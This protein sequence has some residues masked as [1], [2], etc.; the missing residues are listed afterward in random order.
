MAKLGILLLL[1]ICVGLCHTETYSSVALLKDQLAKI[2][3]DKVR[4]ELKDLIV[5]Q[6][7]R[8]DTIK[9]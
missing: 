9:R 6:E 5:E 3:H 4:S 1:L 2:K 7:E 8:L